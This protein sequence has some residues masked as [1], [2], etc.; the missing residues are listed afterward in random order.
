MDW[1]RHLGE[2]VYAAG[3]FGLWI[4]GQ[5]APAMPEYAGPIVSVVTVL[6][7]IGISVWFVYHTTTVTQPEMRHEHA[8]AMAAAQEKHAADMKELIKAFLQQ[9][10]EER[11]KYSRHLDQAYAQHR[12]DI[13][14][15]ET[16][17]EGLAEHISQLRKPGN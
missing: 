2:A 6:S 15:L 12:D 10:T 3:L 14:K 5:A 1:H 16:A 9:S 13:E 7:S 4:I 8:A 11:D 17:I